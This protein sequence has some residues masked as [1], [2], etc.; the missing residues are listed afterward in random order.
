MIY[1]ILI[2]MLIPNNIGQIFKAVKLGRTDR[3][4]KEHLLSAIWIQTLHITTIQGKHRDPPQQI[5]RLLQCGQPPVG[6]VAAVAH[7]PCDKGTPGHGYSEQNRGRC[8]E[9]T[10]TREC[11][12]A[13][14]DQCFWECNGSE[15]TAM[16]ECSC[17]HLQQCLWEV[18][19]SELFAVTES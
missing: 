7:G 11:S 6:A 13:C 10:A 9:S 3:V 12:F 2:L 15:S 17:V 8:V 14:L 4:K 16:S 5:A 18:K 19:G 1:T